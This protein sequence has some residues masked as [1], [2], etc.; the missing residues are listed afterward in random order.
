MQQRG[1]LLIGGIAVW[2]C[3][4]RQHQTCR[5][6]EALSPTLQSSP[7]N[8][9][10]SYASLLITGLRLS[11]QKEKASSYGLAFGFWS[12]FQD[13]VKCSSAPPSPRMPPASL[14]P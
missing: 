12:V 4:D 3:F 11:V 9:E 7:L 2:R 13:M 1:M 5:K 6:I 8:D 14:L 10:K